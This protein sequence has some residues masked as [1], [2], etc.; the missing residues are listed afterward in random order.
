MTGFG[1]QKFMNPRFT[2]KFETLSFQAN[3][4]VDT[5][6][7]PSFNSQNQKM[8]EEFGVIV[9]RR[10]YKIKVI[11]QTKTKTLKKNEISN[12]KKKPTQETIIPEKQNFSA[13]PS[14]VT[15]PSKKE[16]DKKKEVKQEEKKDDKK[17]EVKKEVAPAKTITA[18]KVVEQE[19]VSKFKTKKQFKPGTFDFMLKYGMNPDKVHE[20]KNSK[21][22]DIDL[23]KKYSVTEIAFA[24]VLRKDKE[25]NYFV[26]NAEIQN[27]AKMVDGKTIPKNYSKL[28]F[29]SFTP[30]T[31]KFLEDSGFNLTTIY[32][33]LEA[34]E[35]KET[36]VGGYPTSALFLVGLM[37]KKGDTSY[38]IDAEG[39]NTFKEK[40]KKHW[41]ALSGQKPLKDTQVVSSENNE[42]NS[43]QDEEIEDSG[44]I[45][46]VPHTTQPAEQ[47][48]KKE[49]KEEK[50]EKKEDKKED[51]T[52]ATEEQIKN[53]KT[54][55]IEAL[56]LEQL[57][58]LNEQQLAALATNENVNKVN[59]ETK[60][61][62]YALYE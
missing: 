60:K 55:D 24:K 61:K 27:W 11:P 2:E 47:V 51:I 45:E 22:S 15:T 50:K 14:T 38:S 3:S 19:Q 17:V 32:A 56:T 35:K 6:N 58:K 20:I 4:L 21:D 31:K 39:I 49:K 41:E 59:D 12:S 9:D 36:L 28:G 34:V 53:W 26:N 62:I 30:G 16:K 54:K 1:N 42:I 48:V 10:T 33:M 37:K 44:E 13:N 5:I 43:V 40:D 57:K 7:N 23:L 18:E 25:G 46:Q 8:N 52:K 29:S